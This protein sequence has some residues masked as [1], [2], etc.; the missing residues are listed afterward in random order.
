MC[1][2]RSAAGASCSIGSAG[3]D[4]SLGASSAGNGRSSTAADGSGASSMED[5]NTSAAPAGCVPIPSI[6]AGVSAKG[7]STDGVGS[8]DCG[9]AGGSG[10]GTRSGVGFSGGPGTSVASGLAAG[11]RTENVT[12]HLPHAMRRNSPGSRL[13][14]RR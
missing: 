11:L 6:C 1:V 9:N 5:G 12:P 4:S 7:S 3:A 2:G 10:G 13:W 14:L 8:E